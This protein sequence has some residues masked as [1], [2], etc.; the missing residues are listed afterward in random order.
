MLLKD[1][2]QIVFSFPEKAD[3]GEITLWAT[4]A[5]LH[6]DNQIGELKEENELK[7]NDQCRVMKDDIIIRRIQPQ[8]VNYVD[9]DKSFYIAQNLVIIR[10]KENINAKYLAYIMEKDMFKL[11]KDMMGSILVAINRK[12]FDEF[13]VGN[14][15]DITTQYAIGELWWLEKERKKLYNQ[16][17]D[18]QKQLLSWQLANVLKKEKNNDNI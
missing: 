7:P 15:P 18:K 6:A 14:L 11:Y 1:V 3:A 8:F 9:E 5:S 17:H 13:D 10:A 16:L 12:A 2:A 4:A